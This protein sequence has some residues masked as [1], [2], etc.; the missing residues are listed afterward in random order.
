MSDIK[1][2]VSL[3]S[4]IMET[5][6]GAQTRFKGNVNTDKPIRIDGTFEGDIDSSDLVLISE[7]GSVKGNI[8][9]SEL[10]L[11]GTAEGTAVCQTLMQ[12]AATGRFDGDIATP[13]LITVPGSI[14]NGNCRMTE[15]EIPDQTPA[16]Y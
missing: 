11:F 6:I 7:S 2:T 10:Q 9:C 14:F 8:K 3:S 15:P 5:V 1:E 13:S 12:F 16:E 4:E